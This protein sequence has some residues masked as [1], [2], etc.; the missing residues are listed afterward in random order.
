METSHF[1]GSPIVRHTQGHQ[2]LLEWS[3]YPN[4][5]QKKLRMVVR[6]PMANGLLLK[7][8]SKTPANVC[9]TGNRFYG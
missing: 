5:P 3:A 4:K 6:S 7:M 9:K 8:S 2:H 1:V